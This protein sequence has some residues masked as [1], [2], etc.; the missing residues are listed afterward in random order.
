MTADQEASARRPGTVGAI[1][2][3][4]AA[5]LPIAAIMT[6][7]VRGVEV[8]P[9]LIDWVL[10]AGIALTA[11]AT[12]LLLLPWAARTSGRATGVGL[13]LSVVALLSSF[14]FF[15]TMVPVIFGTAGAWLGYSVKGI[16]G[17]SKR[18]ALLAVA[19]GAL[20]AVASV[21]AYIA[22]G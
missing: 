7:N 9:G 4:V 10:V 8:Q 20:A 18:P 3:L 12:F 22:T 5:G 1:T 17:R 13:V 16:Q 2:L 11:V 14:F 6:A 19:M 21:V 15:W